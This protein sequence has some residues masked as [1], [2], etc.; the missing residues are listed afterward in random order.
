MLQTL[1][2]NQLGPLEKGF[3]KL[4]E[5]DKMDKLFRT[6]FYLVKNER[7]FKDFAGLIEL[8]NRNDARLGATYCNDKAA[9]T[10]E[11]EVADHYADNLLLKVTMIAETCSQ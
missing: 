10:F 11:R 9:Q 4:D 8:Q 2:K 6:A 1:P 5:L 7:P 3:Q